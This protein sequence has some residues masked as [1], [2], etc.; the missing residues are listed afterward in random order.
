MDR[1]AE[2]EEPFRR[3]AMQVEDSG[4]GIEP[5]VLPHLTEPVKFQ[6]LVAASGRVGP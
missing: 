3:L 5:E 1:Q 2:S 6:D 4:I